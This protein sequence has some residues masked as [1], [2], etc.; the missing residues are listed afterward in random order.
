MP[1]QPQHPKDSSSRRPAAPLKNSAPGR[2]A[3]QPKA[4]ARAPVAPPVYRPQPTPVVLQRKTALSQPPPP[5]NQPPRRPAAPPVY[6]PEQKRIAQPKMAQA[7]RQ[8]NPPP[9]YRPQPTTRVLQAKQA[10]NGSLAGGGVGARQHG[11]GRQA[12]AAQARN[13]AQMPLIHP[14]GGT[15]LQLPRWTRASGVAQRAENN[16]FVGGSSGAS[17]SDVTPDWYYC[18]KC[19]HTIVSAS[20]PDFACT[21]GATYTWVEGEPPSSEKVKPWVTVVKS[22]ENESHKGTGAIGR[23]AVRKTGK[24]ARP[25][26]N[27]YP[28]KLQAL[29]THCKEVNSFVTMVN[30]LENVYDIEAVAK[31]FTSEAAIIK[32]YTSLHA[33]MADIAGLGEDE[34]F[35]LNQFGVGGIMLDWLE[36]K[37]RCI[38]TLAQDLIRIL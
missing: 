14:R 37:K 38:T 18:S 28:P 8:Q 29:I 11:G 13:Q 5:P 25:P 2:A 34:W 26:F 22:A 6:R 30:V 3:P 7:P 15:P 10:H 32:C 27:E 23:N 33:M 4:A 35:M 31:Q 36:S 21:C 24:K 1:K 9:A 19:N 16:N 17:T 12:P 20:Y